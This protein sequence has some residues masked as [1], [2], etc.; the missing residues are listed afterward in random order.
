MCY[1]VS[2]THRIDMD[3]AQKRLVELREADPIGYMKSPEYKELLHTISAAG[4][5]IKEYDRKI[6]MGI[7]F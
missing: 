5:H 6:A 2:L 1:D 7:K 3:K 4:H